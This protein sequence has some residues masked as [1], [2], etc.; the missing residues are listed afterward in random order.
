MLLLVIY[1][2]L[3]FLPGVVSCVYSVLLMFL[4]LLWTNLLITYRM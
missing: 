1:G 3:L 2:L 4:D